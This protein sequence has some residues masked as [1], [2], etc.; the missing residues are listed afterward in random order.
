MSVE[1]TPPGTRGAFFPRPLLKLMNGPIWRIFRHRRFAGAPILVL[2]TIGARTGQ[3]R[4]ATLGYF[5]ESNDAWIIVGSAGGAAKH[6]T[7]VYNL[8]KHPDQVWIEVGDRKIKVTPESVKGQE[9]DRIWQ[10]VATEAPAYAAYPSKTDREIPVIR[11]R[12]AKDA[13]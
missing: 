10:R 8:A 6:P 7:W 11:L 3:P 1:L 12:R 5:P 13:G 2:N 9:R 4:T